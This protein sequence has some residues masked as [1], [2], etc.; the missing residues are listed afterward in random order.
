[1]KTK[2]QEPQSEVNYLFGWAKMGYIPWKLTANAP[3]NRPS[4]KQMNHV[5]TIDF[6]S[7]YHK[8]QPNVVKDTSPMDPTGVEKQHQNPW[9]VAEFGECR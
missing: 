2:F 7:I 1:M 5:P 9:G 4:Q 3:E 6:Q 8:I